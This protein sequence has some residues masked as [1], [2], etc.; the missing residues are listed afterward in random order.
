VKVVAG[1]GNAE[2]LPLLD[3]RHPEVERIFLALG[4]GEDC[5]A[6]LKAL[7]ER[8]AAALASV[9]AD[10]DLVVAHNVMTMPFNLGLTAALPRLG[11]PVVAWTHDVAWVNPRYADFRR[12]G[13]PYDLL[14][15]PAPVAYVAISESRR[16]QLASAYGVDAPVVPNGVDP[17]RLLRLRPRTVALLRQAGL[18]GARPLVLVPFRVTRRKRLEDA[19][20]VAARLAPRFPELRWAVSGPLGPHEAANVEYAKRLH[21]L[22]QRLGLE[23]T[24]V[25]LHELGAPGRH[26]VDDQMIAELYSL[27]GAVFLPSESEGFGLPVVEAGLLGVPVVCSDLDV[28]TELAAGFAHRFPVGD[29]EAGAAALTSALEERSAALQRR[30][31]AAF[32]WDAV[33]PKIEK[34]IADALA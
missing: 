22:R 31:A 15:E 12:E 27:A 13:K 14:H 18:W 4:R 8:I 24:F 10:V 3:S 32:T 33:F 5:S 20:E 34:V 1:R 19:L 11:R 17:A 23:R 25:F 21:E 7:E 29:V 9:V 26:P 16:E 30:V 2:V 6:P 28:F